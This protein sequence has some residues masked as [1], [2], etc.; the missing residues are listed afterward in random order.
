[1]RI[2]GVSGSVSSVA[3]QAPGGYCTVTLARQMYL[4]VGDYVELY[5]YQSSGAAVTTATAAGSD[6]GSWLDLRWESM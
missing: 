1:V 2:N 4:N 3:V 5:G 6:G